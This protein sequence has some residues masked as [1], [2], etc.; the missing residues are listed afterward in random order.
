MVECPRC[1]KW[2]EED[3]YGLHC[4]RCGYPDSKSKMTKKYI[5]SSSLEKLVKKNHLQIVL[6][7]DQIVGL[8]AIQGTAT[9]ENWSLP[10]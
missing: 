7:T 2:F 6:R 1:G 5:K 8:V 3:E 9:G 4:P 10:N